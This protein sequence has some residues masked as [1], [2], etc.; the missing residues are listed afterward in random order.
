[1]LMRC[2]A[3]ISLLALRG[4][5]INL[6]NLRTAFGPR[7]V[8]YISFLGFGLSLSAC[9][10]HLEKPQVQVLGIEK[11]SIQLLEQRFLVHLLVTNPN[12]QALPIQSVT[13]SVTINGEEFA[14]GE[15]R[16]SLV[17][18][19]RGSTQ[20]DL[21]LTTNLHSGLGKLITLLTQ[22]ADSFDYRVVGEVKTGM[23]FFR[24]LPF[25]QQGS[26]K[27]PRR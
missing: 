1:M 8:A 9:V 7:I 22:G 12:A 27:L 23:T 17:V 5:V 18:V 10:P 19:A 4:M 25:D 6:K 3:R 21:P 15:L 26:V 13:Y 11:Q 2:V 16:D 20:V 14:R 24:T